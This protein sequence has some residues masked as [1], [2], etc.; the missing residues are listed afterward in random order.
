VNDLRE[1]RKS[2]VSEDSIKDSR[3]SKSPK[4]L[5]LPYFPGEKSVRSWTV[6]FISMLSSHLILLTPEMTGLTIVPRD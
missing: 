2:G 5:S 4:E 3:N 6:A 1:V